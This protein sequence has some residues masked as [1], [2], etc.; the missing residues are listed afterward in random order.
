M[1]YDFAEIEKKLK[2]YLDKD[3]FMHTGSDVLAT[4]YGYGS[5][6]QYGAGSAGICFTIVQSVFPIKVEN[7]PEAGH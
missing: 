2:K 6:N 3:R 4:L 7:L 5:W 1:K